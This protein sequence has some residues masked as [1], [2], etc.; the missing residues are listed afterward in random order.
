[1]PKSA[2]MAIVNDFGTT[3]AGVYRA[4]NEI[5]ETF[6]MSTEA[7]INRLRNLGVLKAAV[8]DTTIPLLF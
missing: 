3:P 4:L 7:V 6:N 1:M 2:V 5:E 8:K